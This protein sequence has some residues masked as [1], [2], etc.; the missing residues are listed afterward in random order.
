[1]RSIYRNM[2]AAAFA[3]VLLF[4]SCGGGGKS[5]AGTDASTDAGDDAGHDAGTDAGTDAGND[6]G[7]DDGGV[8]T[9][10]DLG[11]DFGIL[12]PDGARV[13]AISGASDIRN[14]YRNRARITLKPGLIRLSRD[15]QSIERELIERFE[16]GPEKTAAV[17]QGPGRFTRTIDGSA[18][19]G[20]YHYEFG[21]TFKA[22]DRTATLAFRFSF[23]VKDGQ[24]TQPLLTLDDDTLDSDPWNDIPWQPRRV[25]LRAPITDPQYPYS[26]EL[27]FIT[28]G[29]GTLVRTRV[30]IAIAG[31][32]ALALVFRCPEH[33]AIVINLTTVCPC[34][35]ESARL[36]RAGE[37][38]DVTDYFRL[39]MVSYN[40][41]NLNQDTLVVLDAPLGGVWAVHVPGGPD[42]QAMGA[43]P[44][45][46]YYLD[47]NLQSIDTKAVTGWTVEP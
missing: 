29:T 9:D 26:R 28:C 36:T 21:Q 30:A 12:V 42:S 4:A 22:G 41:C 43:P 40:H 33:Q 38:R 35:M 7:G 5:D 31:N 46:L 18:Q 24:A 10:V 27:G 44:T 20:T 37:T 45:E 8:S 1:M 11:R 39:A 19:N 2:A 13:C 3:A 16:W 6:A 25:L 15:D 23:E 47:A 17:A 14:A 32:D 34:A